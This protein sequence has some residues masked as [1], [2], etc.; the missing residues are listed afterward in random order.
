VWRREERGGRGVEEGGARRQ[1][2]GGGRS[3][4]EE[5]RRPLDDFREGLSSLHQHRRPNLVSG[6]EGGGFRIENWG[7]RV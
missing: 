3:E 6:V 2:C 1:R 5:E 7:F 4:E